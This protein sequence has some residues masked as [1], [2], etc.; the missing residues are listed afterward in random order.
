MQ[1]RR[2]RNSLRLVFLSLAKA[3]VAVEDEGLEGEIKGSR[4]AETRGCRRKSSKGGQTSELERVVQKAN[5][6][7]NKFD[8]I[9]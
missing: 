1:N 2:P 4:G 3:D 5:G 9:N 7:T 6:R 8:E